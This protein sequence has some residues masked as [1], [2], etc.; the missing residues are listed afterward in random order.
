MNQVIVTMLC[1]DEINM[2]D[3]VAPRDTDTYLMNAAWTI[4]STY[5]MVLKTSPGTEIFGRDML[6]DIPY[7]TDWNK[8]GDIGNARLIITQLKKTKLE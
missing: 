2:P 4:C 5:H 1:T 6:F 7:I 8:I 3:S